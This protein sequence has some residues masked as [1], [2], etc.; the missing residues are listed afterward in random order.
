MSLEVKSSVATSSMTEVPHSAPHHPP[1]PVLYEWIY[2]SPLFPF[3]FSLLPLRCMF[4]SNVPVQKKQSQQQ[5]RAISL[6]LPSALGSVSPGSRRPRFPGAISLA[7]RGPITPAIGAPISAADTCGATPSQFAPSKSRLQCVWIT[8][9]FPWL[10]CRFK[11][12]VASLQWSL[13]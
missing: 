2:L 1:S 10:R 12:A 6:P 7:P 9:W 11:S 4:W 8:L 3:T 5:R 13:C